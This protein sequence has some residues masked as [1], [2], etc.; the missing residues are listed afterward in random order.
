MGEAEIIV[1]DEITTHDRLR[2]V[3]RGDNQQFSN[4]IQEGTEVGR[5]RSI[6]NNHARNTADADVTQDN[7]TGFT[8]VSINNSYASTTMSA[9]K[10]LVNKI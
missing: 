9:T 5:W 2:R 10:R 3:G 8:R 4:I 1:S 7:V 6:N